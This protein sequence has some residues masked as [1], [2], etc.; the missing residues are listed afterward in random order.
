[1]FSMLASF[2][3]NTMPIWFHYGSIISIVPV[4]SGVHLRCLGFIW[5]TILNL[6]NAHPSLHHSLII[7]KLGFDCALENSAVKGKRSDIK[8]TLGSEK[9]KYPTMTGKVDIFYHKNELKI[10]CGVRT[11]KPNK[12]EVQSPLSLT[13][14]D[15]MERL[16]F[17]V[18]WEYHNLGGNPFICCSWVRIYHYQMDD[19]HYF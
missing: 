12:V 15:W 8:D 7:Y 19:V 6:S 10:I 2:C 5:F 1:M 9:N 13:F 3:K 16:F 18:K 11:S 17:I 4:I 14:G